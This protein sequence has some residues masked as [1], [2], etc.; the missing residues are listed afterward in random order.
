MDCG[1]WLLDI[2][3]WVMDGKHVIHT[4]TYWSTN[5]IKT[6]TSCSKSR[7]KTFV[8]EKKL[9]ESLFLEA[10]INLVPWGWVRGPKSY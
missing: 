7:P 2:E 1:Y 6:V 8:W 3:L 10:K 4:P 5:S 9:T